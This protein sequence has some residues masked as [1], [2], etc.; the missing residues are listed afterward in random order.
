MTSKV[1]TECL[2]YATLPGETARPRNNWLLRG[3]P[4]RNPVH[5]GAAYVHH[6]AVSAFYAF[7]LFV[8]IPKFDESDFE[9]IRE[10]D[11]K[12]TRPRNSFRTGH[13][14]SGSQNPGAWPT[15]SIGARSVSSGSA[16]RRLGR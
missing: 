6:H 3:Q 15:R 16:V 12:S 14:L 13:R 9:F 11:N 4:N 10:A 5:C 8:R 7:I 1:S 2:V